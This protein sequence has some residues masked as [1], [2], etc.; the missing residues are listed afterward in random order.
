MCNRPKTA[1]LA[2][3]LEA[4][5]RDRLKE[6]AEHIGLAPA[7]YARMLIKRDLNEVAEPA[8]A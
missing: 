2:V 7:T 3:P 5:D 6:K 1:T 4:G 8:A